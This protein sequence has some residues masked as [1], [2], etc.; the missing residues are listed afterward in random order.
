MISVMHYGHFAFPFFNFGEIG[1][2]CV[3]YNNKKNG[4]FSL[5]LCP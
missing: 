5:N 3:Y 2:T 1:V 4:N